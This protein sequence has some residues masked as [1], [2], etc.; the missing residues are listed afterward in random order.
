[1]MTHSKIA[2]SL[3]GRLCLF[4]AFMLLLLP[5]PWVL[6]VVAAT[7]VH[8]IC[9][10][11]AIFAFQ[12]ELYSLRLGAGGII[13]ETNTFSPGRE[14]IVAMAGPIG[15]A[16]LIL[17]AHRMPR[18]AICGAIHCIY[19]MLPILPLDGGRIL[20][21]LL[22]LFLPISHGRK[23]FQVL[24]HFLCVLLML[25]GLVCVFRWGL[26]AGLI[27]LPLIWRHGEKRTV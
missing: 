20:E 14:L 21:N 8:E 2:I 24:Q 25:L 17:L 11:L 6:S 27:F 22:A 18:L 3:D 1:M 15:S 7:L 19:N 10:V 12:G 26:F 4:L 16:L 9:H 23:I 13:M 5:L